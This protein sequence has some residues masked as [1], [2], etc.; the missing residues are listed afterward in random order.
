[1]KHRL[2]SFLLLC[3]IAA[4]GNAAV[5]YSLNESFESGLLPSTWSQEIVNQVVGGAWFAENSVDGT[6][7]NPGSAYEGEGRA[8]LRSTANGEQYCVRLI[9]PAL[10]LSAVNN[11]QLSF[12]Y[13]QARRSS[14]SDTLSVYFR[15]SSTDPWVLLRKYDQY[16]N[17]WSHQKLELP[18]ACRVNGCQFAFEGKLH[19]AGYGVVLDAVKVFPGSLCMEAQFADPIILSHEAFITWDDRSGRQFELLI[20]SAYI[21][22]M[23]NYDDKDVVFHKDDITGTDYLVDGLNPNTHYYAYLRTDCDDNETGYTEWVSMEFTTAIGVPYTPVLSAIPSTW[24]RYTGAAELSVN[25]KELEETTSGWT[26]TTST[27]V[28]G[29]G[30]LYANPSGTPYWATTPAIDLSGLGANASIAVTFDLAYTSGPSSASES[31]YINASK[32]HVYISSDGGETWTIERTINGSDLSNVGRTFNVLLDAYKDE[33]VRLAFVAEGASTS[34]YMHFGAMTVHE[35]DPSCLGIYGLKTSATESSINLSW[36]VTG[37]NRN[38]VAVLSDQSDFSDTLQSKN[39]NALSTSFTGL[40]PQTT[41]YV[42][43]RQ[44]CETGNVLTAKVKT[45]CVAITIDRNN[46][47]T[48]NFES[49]TGGSDYSASTVMSADCWT[50]SG[51]GNKLFYIYNSSNGGNTTKQ[52]AL[53][54]MSSGT[55][56]KLSLPSMA[57]DEADA[58]VFM[59]DIYRNSTYATKTNEGI[60]VYASHTTDIDD[61]A[62][63]MAFIPRVYSVASSVIPAEDAAGWYRYELPIPLDG[64]VSII[65]QG[66]S[67]YGAATYMDNFEVSRMPDCRKVQGVAVSVVDGHSAN[68]SFSFNGAPR[69]E[70]LVVTKAMNP[71]TLSTDDPVAYRQTVSTNTVLVNTLQPTTNYYVYI[72]ALCSGSEQGAWSTVRTFTTPCETIVPGVNGWHET[73]E[74]LEGDDIPNC[75]DNSEGTTTSESYKWAS[76]ISGYEGRGLRFNSYSNQT[77]L[78]NILATPSINLDRASILSFWWKNPTGGSARVMVGVEGSTTRDTIESA[79]TNVTDWR[80]YELDLSDY[81]GQTVVIYFLGTSNYGYGD[82]YL[83]L[84]EVTV[85]YIPTCH[86]MGAVSLSNITSSSATLRYSPTNAGQ[87]QVVVTTVSIDPETLAEVDPAV[88]VYN[89][90]VTSTQPR[91]PSLNGNTRYYAY[92]RGYCGGD[93]Y[94]RWSKE[95]SFKTLCTE[96]TPDAFG[97]ETF[98]DPASVD[99]WTFGFQTS[100]PGD[101]NAFAGRTSEPAY[102]AYI[103]LSKEAVGAKNVHDVDSVCSDGAYAISPKLDVDDISNYQVTFDAATTSQATTNYKRLNI[104]IVINPSDLSAIETLKTI[105]LDYAADSNSIKSYTVSFADYVG[106]YMGDKGQY[107]I[108]MLNEPQKHDSTNFVLIDNVRFDQASSCPQVLESKVDSIGITGA[109]ISWEDTGAGEYEVM[110]ATVNSRR[111]DTISAPVVVKKV[112]VNKAEVDNL[113]GNTVYFAYIRGICGVGDTARWSNSIRFRTAIGIPYD[114]PFT[115][116]SLS[117]GWQSLYGNFSSDSILTSSLST[118][119]GEYKWSVVSAG[120]PMDMTS[121]AVYGYIDDYYYGYPWLISPT[122][123]LVGHEGDALELTF[124]IARSVTTNSNAKFYVIIS[125]DG[126]RSWTKANATTWMNGGDYSYNELTTE[127]TQYAI[128]LTQ[129]GGKKIAVAFYMQ[130]P[131]GSTHIENG[132]YID[133]VSVHTYETVCR[134]VRHLTVLPEEGAVKVSW[135]IEGTPVKTILEL[136]ADATLSTRVDSVTV[137]DVYEHTFTGLSSNTKYYV[138][139]KQADCERA[140]WR[141]ISFSTE[142]GA[143][144]IGKNAPWIEDFES[145]D[146]TAYNVEN[147]QLTCWRMG[148]NTTVKPHAVSSGTYGYYVHSGTKSLTFYGSA[149]ST[150]YAALPL[151][152]EALNNLQITFWTRMESTSAGTLTLGYITTTDPGDFSTFQVIETCTNKTTMTQYEVILNTLPANAHRLVFCWNYPS[153]SWYT[154]AVDDIEVGMIPPCPKTTGLTVGNID[155]DSARLYVRDFG[156]RGYEFIVASDQLNLAAMTAADSANIV[157]NDSVIGDTTILVTGLGT[158]R[159][160]FAYARQL[161]EEGEIGAWSAAKA[162]N[163]SCGTIIVTAGMPW[164][165][166]F[167]NLSS[168]IPSCW[169]NSEGTTTTE[170]Y[171]WSYYASGNSG[172]C[173]RFESYYNSNGNTNFL[174]TPEIRLVSDAVLSFAW[175]NPAGGAGEVLISTDG[176]TTKTSLKNNL[177]GISNWTEYEIDLAAYTGQT[178]IIYFKGTSNWSYT[179][180][181]ALFLDDVK[182]RAIPTCLPVNG[183]RVDSIGLD[184]AY[185]FFDRKDGATYDVVVAS[186]ELD[187]YR[188]TP[189]DS[190]K[191]VFSVDETEDTTM[192]VSNLLPSTTYYIYERSHCDDGTASEWSAAVSFTT[193]CGAIVVTDAGWTEDFEGF[194]AGTGASGAVASPACWATLNAMSGPYAYV[195]SETSNSYSWLH[196]GQYLFFN[197]S[198]GST[199]Q[200]AHYILPEFE[201]LNTLQIR[202]TY[203]FEG[204]GSGDIVLGYMTDITDQST[205][206]AVETIAHGSITSKTAGQSDW[207]GLDVIPDSVLADA[208]LAFRYTGT[209]NWYANVDDLEITLNTG[210][211]AVKNVKVDNITAYAAQVT[212]TDTVASSYDVAVMTQALN[213]D[214]TGAS[215]LIAFRDTVYIDTAYVEGLDPSTTYYVYVRALCDEGHSPWSPAVTFMTECSQFTVGAAGWSEDFENYEGTTYDNTGVMPNCWSASAAGSIAPHVIGSGTYHYKHSGTKSLTFYGNGNCYAVLPEFTNALNSLQINFWM[216]TEHA[217]YGKLTLGYILADDVNMNTFTAI[218]QYANHTGSMVECETDLSELPEEAVR[219]V[220]CWTY[221]SQYSC[222][223]DDIQLSILPTCRPS[224]KIEFTDVTASSARVIFTKTPSPSYDFIVTSAAINPDTIAGVDAS[225]IFRHDTVVVNKV[226]LAGLAPATTYY[227]YLRG[228]CSE[229]ELSPWSSAQFMTMCLASLPYRENFE[230]THDRKAVYAGTNLYMIPTCWSEGYDT[231]A[232]VSYIDNNTSSNSYAYS[233]NSALRLYSQYASLK[234]TLSTS[235]V[236][237]PEMDALLDTLQLTFKARAMYKNGNSVMNY[238]KSTHAHSVKVGTMTD[239]QDFSTFH[240]LETYELATVATTP[241]SADGYWEDVTIYLQGAVGKYIALVSDFAKTN[242]VWIDDVEVSQAPA[243]RTPS[244]IGVSAGARMAD[245]HWAST[246]SEFEVAIGPAGFSNPD[247]ADNIFTVSDTL[248]LHIPDLEPS[249]DYDLYVR[250]QCEPGIYSD[251][252]KVKSFST[253]CLLPDFAEYHFDDPDTRYVHHRDSVYE[254]DYYGYISRDVISDVYMENC[255]MVLGYNEE[256]SDSYYESGSTIY[257]TGVK[258]RYPFIVEN[259]DSYTYAHSAAGAIAFECESRATPQAAI[260]P[261]FE[262]VDRDSLQLEFWARPGYATKSYTST[263]MEGASASSARM[264]RVGLMTDLNDLATF[265]PLR[266][267]RC[268]TISGDPSADPEGENY[269]RRYRINLAGTTAPYIAFVYD[270]T[271]SNNFFIDDVCIRKM[272][273]CPE[274]DAPILSDITDSSVVVRWEATA[275]AYQVALIH[276]TDT[277][278]TMVVENDTLQIIGLSGVTSYIVKLRAFCNEADSSEWSAAASFTTECARITALPWIEDFETLPLGNSTSAAPLCWDL[279]NANDG[280]YPYIYVNNSSSYVQSGEHSLYF[281]SS[282]TRFGYAI[283]PEFGVPTNALKVTFSYRDESSSSS[284]Y[285]ALGYM[286]DITDEASFEALAI[287]PLTTSFRTVSA[288][289]FDIP[290]AVASSARLVFRY[291]GGTSNNYYMAIDDIRVEQLNLSCLGVKDVVVSNVTME[292]AQVDFRF[293][294]GLPHDAQVAISREAAYDPSTA[295]ETATISDTSYVFHVNLEDKA[296]YYIYVRQVCDGGNYSAWESVSFT[297]PYR[298][299]YE[300]E[301]T[302]T[303]LPDDWTRYTGALD[304]VLAGT[305]QLTETSSGWNVV[306]ADTVLNAYHFRGNI[307]GTSWANWAVSPSIMLN[308]DPDANVQLRFDAGLTPYSSSAAS[309]RNTGTDDRFVVL[310]STDNGATWHILQEWNNSG[311]QDVYNAIPEH[312]KT[313]F[314]DLSG[315]IGQMVKLAFYGESTESNADNYF[316]FGNIIVNHTYADDYSGTVC[317]G[318]DYVG[319]D[320]GNSFYITPDMY[321][322]GENIF[323][324]YR[325]AVNGSGLPD[326]VFTL[327]LNAIQTQKYETQVTVCEDEHYVD[328]WHGATFDFIAF[329][330]MNDPVRFVDN[331]YGCEDEVVLHLTVIRRVE[332]H[333]YDTIAPGEQYDWHGY[334]YISSTVVSYDT[335]SLVTG[336]DSTVYLHLHVGKKTEDIHGVSA[337]GLVI[338]PNPVHVGEP[339][340]V[341]NDF[342]AEELENA[343]IEIYSSTGALYHVQRGAEQPFV[344]PAIH[345]SGMYY[346][347]II[348]EDKIYLSPLLVQ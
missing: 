27:T 180:G 232:V 2:L 100:R 256:V 214:M 344:L 314:V 179:S 255:W 289:T 43:V 337:Q 106:D 326:S 24:N 154:S 160:Y 84:D 263:I 6:L 13:A 290:E 88:I 272:A 59:L 181:A 79:L 212:F 7:T 68:I 215:A 94:S 108:F 99:C 268:E 170:S 153:S 236:V 206:H 211:K 101:P 152:S 322:P 138:R 66:E 10:D 286:T 147:D 199:S 341:L 75:W 22:D 18:A 85:E 252:S 250:V 233:G 336:C 301:F 191:I 77:G 305:Q 234:Q 30:H 187:M 243:C 224:K 134:G 291:G 306:S 44:N 15:V 157:F 345:V 122:I 144:A 195:N 270:S 198:N 246:A 172:A 36:L 347:R 174:A 158:G 346:V 296:T 60:R 91:I 76:Y 104:G 271:A 298:I 161:C 185:I 63:E 222:C 117:D 302:S 143:I 72:R 118:P 204:N 89:T 338:A 230:D 295:D 242:F 304:N 9:T 35:V 120:M 279:L 47:W 132:L 173:V 278:K 334:S 34:G 257:Q 327:T 274:P 328:T 205:F 283:L 83:Y 109:K 32:F 131:Y 226:T 67:E 266:T 342:L 307:Y 5:N 241:S 16:Q 213:P 20:S 176:G 11:P 231:T 284:G 303:T 107:V 38:A 110:L 333:I 62:V 64:T 39:V 316:H 142:C 150:S 8:A 275:S 146:G 82:A 292:S 129:Y 136:Y 312:A 92:V 273:T 348:I 137:E 177:S 81:T 1:M 163:S 86:H 192:L 164:T 277:T 311:S 196:S 267:I 227:V 40:N 141:T 308:A 28:L 194:P 221:T 239:P 45:P 264:L 238:A 197:G 225:L 210:C 17:T 135:E 203:A 310:V 193:D 285:L 259:S 145:Y 281:Q 140:V 332:E 115:L 65:L 288:N 162:F 103:K 258:G 237:L 317:V 25:A 188:L 166:N 3:C 31:S 229:E 12:A 183:L 175:K 14:Y 29:V 280:D 219:L 121:P 19:G 276:G 201:A 87:Y 220:F 320:F 148:G 50:N 151:F 23:K 78:T 299:R 251:W 127:A 125:E 126:G 21:A 340:R 33:S 41:Y 217:S 223:I 156:A 169:D 49:Y 54:D 73:F 171:K 260:M 262:V 102:G 71:D 261:A 128:T 168:G 209:T 114:E 133:D 46:S 96:M 130:S 80:Q 113:E 139:A 55:L 321:Q 58:Y 167:N 155:A 98:D 56:T 318:N 293:V 249:T 165:E 313:F 323:H 93:D 247:E 216:Q 335:K 287:Y 105:D 207:I 235:Y 186:A 297:T 52:L 248:G 97:W 53:P 343:R 184:S 208:R 319:A 149:Y 339:V 42:S 119:T 265:E 240:L 182:V 254:E 37:T 331:G 309:K 282:N 253:M 69:Y 61:S 51:N 70:V 48:D 330:G 294:D 228:I 90:M 300:A 269:W 116:L 178:V 4:T 218:E 200:Y 57:I 190:T 324:E 189:A 244:A 124:S 325:P 123:D 95:L 111:P 315:Y 74:S 202:F 159:S 245:V 26:A 329:A 112:S